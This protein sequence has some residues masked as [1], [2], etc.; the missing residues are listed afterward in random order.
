M[1]DFGGFDCICVKLCSLFLQRFSVEVW[2]LWKKG[3]YEASAALGLSKSQTFFR[4]IL[5]Q[6]IK[7]VIPSTANEVITLVK[8]YFWHTH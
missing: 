3:Q 1:I 6:V 7:R 2:I 4:I 5:P 8:R